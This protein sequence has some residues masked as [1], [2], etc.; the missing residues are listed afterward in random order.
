MPGS[1]EPERAAIGTPSSGVKP[2][3]VSTQRPSRTADT[4][5]PPPRWQTTSRGAG[6]R[7]DDHCTESPWKPKRRRP[8]SS[9][10]RRGTG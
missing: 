1:T 6:T 5:H 4:E 3:L 8:H 7:S 10:Q 9:V 2:M